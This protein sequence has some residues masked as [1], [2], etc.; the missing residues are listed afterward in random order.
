M[1]QTV[2]DRCKK[3]V[4]KSCRENIED[5]EGNYVKLKQRSRF[6]DVPDKDIHLCTNCHTDFEKFLANKT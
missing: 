1:I 3:V 4:F 6:I 2:C 5:L